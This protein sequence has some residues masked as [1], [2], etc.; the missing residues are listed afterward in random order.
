MNMWKGANSPLGVWLGLK[1]VSL[2]HE[3]GL[4]VLRRR[5]PKATPYHIQSLTGGAK[6]RWL[7]HGADVAT[8]CITG[9][10]WWSPPAS[11][12]SRGGVRMLVGKR[13][14]RRTSWW[15]RR[16]GLVTG[17]CPAARCDGGAHGLTVWWFYGGQSSEA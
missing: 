7:P 10:Q 11:P 6:P 5:R 13:T 4:T 17:A 8:M 15:W 2:G 1:L 14:P 12:G 3:E 16:S 9:G